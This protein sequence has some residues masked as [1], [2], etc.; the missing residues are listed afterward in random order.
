MEAATKDTAAQ[1]ARRRRARNAYLILA[2]VAAIVA[3]AWFGHRWWTHGK[4]D[5]DDAQVEGDV[6]LVAPRVG[7]VIKAARVHD[8]QAVKAGDVLF[9]LDPIDLDVE[10]ARCEAELEAARAQQVAAD[11]QVGVA[12]SSSAGGLSSARAALTG[13]GASVRSA[14]EATRAAEAAVARARADLA[15]AESDFKRQ[16]DLFDKGAGTRRDVE[17]A[18][19][20]RDVAK[21]ALDAATA[22]LAMARDQRGLAQARVAEAEGHVTQSAPVGQVVTAAQAAARLAAARVTAAEVALNKAKLQRG[23]ATVVAPTAGTVSKLGAH[24]GQQVMSGQSLL[25]LVPFETYVIANFK[26]GQIGQMKP[27]DPVDIEID[28]FPGQT[29]HGVVDSVSPATGA[30]F[31]MIPPDNATGNFVKV[32]QRVPVKITWTA[33]QTTAMRPGLSAEVTVHVDK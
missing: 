12:Q 10:V 18:Q 19:Q 5:T 7:G 31:S 1:L 11:A 28:A 29:F 17:H 8:H 21:A 9:E 33:P 23:Y 27:G 15:S 32:V 16:Q 24:P 2:A 13:A 4:Q 20:T 30:R 22:Q 25:M 26:E 14:D 6:V 3:I